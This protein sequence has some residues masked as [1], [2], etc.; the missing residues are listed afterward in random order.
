MSADLFGDVATVG[1]AAGTFGAVGTAVWAGRKAAHEV[2]KQLGTQRELHREQRVFE[3][4]GTL[5]SREFTEMSAVAADVIDLF[6]KNQ[7][8]ARA[9]WETGT[10]NREAMTVLAALNFYELIA[11]E[12]NANAIDRR[13]ANV[14]LGYAAV[15]MWEYAEPFVSYL[16]T[17]D[18]TYYAEWKRFY[19]RYR[20]AIVAAAQRHLDTDR[21][22]DAPAAGEVMDPAPP[23][24]EAIHLPGPTILPL[25]AAVAITLILVGLTTTVFLSISGALLLAV[26]AV[27]WARENTDELDRLP[28]GQPPW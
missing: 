4:Q 13:T 11:T 18:D 6:G 14:Y 15:R 2:D 24:G 21:G 7:R 1:V 17:R 3:L 10:S 23:V 16:R 12:Y 8:W 27:R 19:D 9:R 26:A 5:S 22:G 28:R 20:E 25:L